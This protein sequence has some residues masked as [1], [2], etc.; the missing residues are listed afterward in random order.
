[1]RLEDRAYPRRPM[2]RKASAGFPLCQRPFRTKYSLRAFNSIRCR[3]ADWRLAALNDRACSLH[4]IAIRVDLVDLAEVQVADPRFYLAH[5]AH[6]HPNQ[7]AR[8]NI[9]LRGLVGARW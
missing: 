4:R 1:M 6:H 2:V 9:F 5:I 8:Q 3:Q 7:L